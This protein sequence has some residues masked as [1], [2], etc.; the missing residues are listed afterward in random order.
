MTSFSLK[1]LAI[2]CMLIDHLGSLIL[3]DSPSYSILRA[4]GR[5]CFPIMAYLIA[6]GFLHTRNLDRYILRLGAFALISEPI[7]DFAFYSSWA[8]WDS[9]NIFFTLLLGLLA[10]QVWETTFTRSKV[11][12]IAL[13]L[14]LVLLAGLISADYGGQGV[15][16]VLLC[17]W[18]HKLAPKHGKWALYGCFLAGTLLLSLSPWILH[19]IPCMLAV[20]PIALYNG[21][22]GPKLTYFF[23]AFYP[24]H[25]LALG[26]LAK[27]L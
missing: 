7:F 20:F 8:F 9:Q 14:A 26:I 18:G 15:L 24:L 27:I 13:L 16:L 19:Q 10:I 6:E 22:R 5:L 12:G 4:I 3:Y 17:H 23:Y 25:L 11:Q 2:T 21:K 1:I